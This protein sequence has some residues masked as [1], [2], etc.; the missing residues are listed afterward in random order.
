MTEQW[1]KL[2]EAW[3]G[4]LGRLGK[5]WPAEIQQAIGEY[6]EILMRETVDPR[7]FMEFLRGSGESFTGFPGAA[8]GEARCDPYVILGLERTATDE[9][10]K[11]RYHNLVRKLHPDTAGVEGTERLFQMVL[12][13]YEAIKRE[14]GLQ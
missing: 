2:T 6:A 10:V 8:N 11:K 9:E 1:Q 5:E 13:A 4:E 14:R 7:R 12:A 3:L